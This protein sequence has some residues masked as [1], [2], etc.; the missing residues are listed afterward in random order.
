[1]S[2]VRRLGLKYLT[3]LHALLKTESSIYLERDAL[4][5]LLSRGTT[6]GISFEKVLLGFCHTI[7]IEIIVDDVKTPKVY[8]DMICL[9]KSV[10]GLS[11]THQLIQAARPDIC[12]TWAGTPLSAIPISD[13]MIG[14]GLV[15]EV[16]RP[17]LVNNPLTA[18]TAEMA[19]ATGQLL[20]AAYIAAAVKVSFTAEYMEMLMPSALVSTFVSGLG[21]ISVIHAVQTLRDHPIK[22]GYVTYIMGDRDI[23]LDLL[24]DRLRETVDQLIVSFPPIMTHYRL[25]DCHGMVMDGTVSQC[26]LF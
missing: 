16:Y 7:Q 1:M 6:W 18:L 3:A 11:L 20:D 22:T 13:R 10:R 14:L 12:R 5:V 23:M 26:V 19:A 17:T 2:V 25:S 8:M 4:E 15:P 24:V 21:I 9:Q